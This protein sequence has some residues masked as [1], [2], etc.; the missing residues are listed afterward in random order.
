MAHDEYSSQAPWV[1]LQE[2]VAFDLIAQYAL[3]AATALVELAPL[4]PELPPLAVP[5][6]VDPPEPVLLA[7]AP[8][9]P[10]TAPALL[11]VLSLQAPRVAVATSIPTKYSGFRFIED[12]FIRARFKTVQQHFRCRLV[13]WPE[14]FDS[15]RFASRHYSL[16][17]TQGPY[18][19]SACHIETAVR[20]ASLRNDVAGVRYCECLLGG[21]S[22]TWAPLVCIPQ[23]QKFRGSTKS[24]VSWGCESP[25]LSI[26]RRRRRSFHANRVFFVFC[27]AQTLLR[28]L[29]TSYVA[30]AKRRASRLS[31]SAGSI[32]PQRSA[33]RRRVKVTS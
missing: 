2:P 8:P 10:P 14:Y 24:A 21:S 30:A 4:A 23:E 22:R 6:L 9:C 3:Q 17:R 16:G 19:R 33:E 18:Q 26:R 11:S 5:V 7:V 27:P 32:K 13:T 1:I 31:Q 28:L 25:H 15:D 20:C 12:P 29:A